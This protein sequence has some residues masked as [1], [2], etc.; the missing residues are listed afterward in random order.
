MHFAHATPANGDAKTRTP[1]NDDD[2][3]DDN[4]ESWSPSFIKA[5]SS[6]VKSLRPERMVMHMWQLVRTQ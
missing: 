6:L 1:T 4:A 5:T 3:D 2:D